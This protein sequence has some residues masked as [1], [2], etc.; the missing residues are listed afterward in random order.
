MQSFAIGNMEKWFTLELTT[1]MLMVKVS[2]PKFGS[3]RAATWSSHDPTV[4]FLAD[5]SLVLLA[6][7]NF[8]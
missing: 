5:S 6:N 4:D 3:R 1:L 7:P 2:S 8:S